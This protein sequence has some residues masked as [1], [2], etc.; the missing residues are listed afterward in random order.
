[1][2][3]LQGKTWPTCDTFSTLGPHISLDHMYLMWSTYSNLLWVTDRFGR[4]PL[5]LRKRA[6]TQST[7]CRL[8]DLR[9][10]TQFPF[11]ANQWSSRLKPSFCQWQATR[12]TRPISL[13]CDWYVQYLLAGANQ[14]VLNR[15]RQGLQPWRCR[16]STY[17]SPIF[18]TSCFP[19]SPKGPAWSPG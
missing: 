15:H 18:P 1:M 11:Q 3:T 19:F 6:P 8:T 2:Y 16:L 10:R 13:A 5:L 4:I 7:S 17:H 14:S 9:V 12:L